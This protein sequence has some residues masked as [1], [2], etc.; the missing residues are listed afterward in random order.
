MSS[1][2]PPD[3]LPPESFAWPALD[4]LEAFTAPERITRVDHVLRHR[5]GSVT[6]VFEDVFDPHNV[7]ACVRTC[8]GFG[9]QDLHT[10]VNRHGVRLSSTVAK[11]AD[12]WVDLHQH[13]GTEAGIAALK[14][15]GFAIYVSD[16]QATQTL[17]ELPL[18]AKVAIVVGNAKDG[19]SQ[20]MREA[21][22]RRY[23]L[24][25]Y[26]MVQSYNLS[27]ALALSLQHVLP[28]RRAELA[29]HQGDLPM[30]RMWALRQRWLEYG[31]R[32]AEVMRR[33]LGHPDPGQT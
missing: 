2:L 14:A 33:E 32:H 26:G 8:E 11:S 25:M 16:L 20:A 28:R 7:A 4:P 15:Q 19:I 12:Q 3:R 10:I 22:D 13:Q 18:D 31:M 29:P 1:Q 24:P 27:V 30:A 23:I 5:I 6:A 17:A 21:A 9:L